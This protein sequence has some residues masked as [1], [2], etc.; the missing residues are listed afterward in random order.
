MEEGAAGGAG[1]GGRGPGGVGLCFKQ[2]TQWAG[3]LPRHP[4]AA[5]EPHPSGTGARQ[6]LGAC[7]YRV[8]K[9]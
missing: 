1:G 3:A 6:F 2:G 7:P 9:C 5:S 8:A 4:C